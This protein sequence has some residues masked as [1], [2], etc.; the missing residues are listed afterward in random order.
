MDVRSM[1]DQIREAG[2]Q[3]FASPNNVHDVLTS[4]HEVIQATQEALAGIGHQI[5]EQPGV[6]REYGEAAHE[7]AGSMAGVADGLQ[8]QVGPGIT[9]GA[10]T[11]PGLQEV[12]Q[13]IREMSGSEFQDS[14]DVHDTLVNLHEIV[15]A[16]QESMHNLGM[17]IYDLPGVVPEYSEAAFEAAGRMSGI[18]DDLQAKVGQGI[19]G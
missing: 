2:A 10:A 13:G 7:A 17:Q 19:T 14:D 8:E 4:M 16:T 12:A 15:A 9:G 6:V 18:A 11:G 3:E 1:A 5:D